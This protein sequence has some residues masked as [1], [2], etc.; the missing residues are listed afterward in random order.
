[1]IGIKEKKPVNNE[2]FFGLDEAD[3]KRDVPSIFCA[4]ESEALGK[5]RCGA[6]TGAHFALHSRPSRQ[7]ALAVHI[8]AGKRQVVSIKNDILRTTV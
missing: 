2:R 6:C 4:C 8:V 5:T 3:T 7:N 1:M